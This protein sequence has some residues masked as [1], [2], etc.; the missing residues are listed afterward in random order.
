MTAYNVAR[1]P[2]G[3]A[4]KKL[5]SYDGA[6]ARAEAALGHARQA[7][8]QVWTH[9]ILTGDG[10]PTYERIQAKW[11]EIQA[12]PD[13]EFSADDAG[14]LM[15]EFVYELR[16]AE[17]ELARLRGDNIGTSGVAGRPVYRY[18]LETEYERLTRAEA[19]NAR[20]ALEAV[21]WIITEDG[22]VCLW[23]K[24]VHPFEADEEHAP[25]LEHRPDCPRQLALGLAP[26]PQS[27]PAENTE[28]QPMSGLDLIFEE[29][30]RQI[31]SEGYTAEH[32]AQH[33]RGEMAYAAAAYAVHAGKKVQWPEPF[34][35][36]TPPIWPWDS[37]DWKP[38][39][40][41]IR[42]LVKAGALIAAEIDRLLARQPQPASAP[43]TT[44]AE[45]DGA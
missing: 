1:A 29:R 3:A 33:T 34:D 17:S 22:Y 38:H 43:E 31:S 40:Y 24:K 42:N 26:S 9:F 5:A 44:A 10:S 45:D 20:S 15:A 35:D 37:A 11:R 13:Q 8:A 2:E 23:C 36:G 6:K 32:D 14:R 18:V 7:E 39:E 27:A 16:D 25:D 41:P 12:S 4:P 28:I 21:E 30:I 19:A